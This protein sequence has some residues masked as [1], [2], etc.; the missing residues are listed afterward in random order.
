[1]ALRARSG[2]VLL[3]EQNARAALQVADYAYVLENGRV[4]LQGTS[5]ELAQ[6]PRV[7]QTY[8]GMAP[9]VPAPA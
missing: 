9:A 3:V 6:D 5:A 4:T 7:I 1:M 2:A 8:L